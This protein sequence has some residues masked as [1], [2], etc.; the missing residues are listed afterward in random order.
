MQTMNS[1]PALLALSLIPAIAICVIAYWVLPLFAE[2][3]AGFQAEM[4]IQSRILFDLYRF[5]V[6]LP[7][8]VIAVWLWWPAGERRHQVALT[9]GIGG[10]SLFFAYGV[11]AAY[12]PLMLLGETA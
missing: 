11:W 5:I 10:S 9:L 2:V 8:S 12:A 7:A 4:P 3:Y 6:I 1:R